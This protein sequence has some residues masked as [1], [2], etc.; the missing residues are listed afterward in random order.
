MPKAI[1][2][3]IKYRQVKNTPPKPR[4]LLGAAGRAAAG[5][6]QRAVCPRPP[7]AAFRPRRACQPRFP[8]L[9]V[10]T[11]NQGLLKCLAQQSPTPVC[12][13]RAP[14]VF[15]TETPIGRWRGRLA[16]K[17]I[18]RVTSQNLGALENP[19]P[20]VALLVLCSLRVPPGRQCCCLHFG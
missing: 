16:V 18:P 14:G 15:P 4:A 8:C 1:W 13:G 19:V 2:V 7:A 11:D 6:E 17:A 9:R 3:Y 5:T 20:S 12:T 10:A